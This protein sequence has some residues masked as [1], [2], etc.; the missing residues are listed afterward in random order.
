MS[1]YDSLIVKLSRSHWI[2]LVRST[3]VH[4]SRAYDRDLVDQNPPDQCVSFCA[5][6]RM[7]HD[8]PRHVKKG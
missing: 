8:P 2:S 7:L 3:V 6:D 4:S 5:F 1:L